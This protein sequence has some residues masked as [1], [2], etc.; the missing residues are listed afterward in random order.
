[1]N[2]DYKENYLTSLEGSRS[3]ETID[4]Y[5]WRSCRVRSMPAET[6]QF[7]DVRNGFTTILQTNKYSS[8]S[9][10]VFLDVKVGP[11]GVVESSDV[12]LH[13]PDT[14]F[15][16]AIHAM[17]G[18]LRYPTTNRNGSPGSA[19]ENMYIILVSGNQAVIPEEILEAQRNSAR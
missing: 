18:R 11:D 8:Y 16:T 17:A 15:E 7:P 13:Q 2:L 4:H 19:Y 12:R 3:Y 10:W 1:G 9:G 14:G 5:D 6:D